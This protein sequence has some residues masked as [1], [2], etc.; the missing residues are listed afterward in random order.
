MLHHLSRRLVKA[1]GAVR[2]SGFPWATP[3]AADTPRAARL[4]RRHARARVLDR[5][6]ALLR[7]LAALLMTVAWP[8]QTLV[9]AVRMARNAD[10]PARDRG[11]LARA[12]WRV[13]LRHNVPP[14]EYLAYR[15]PERPEVPVDAWLIRSEVTRLND[16]LAGRDAALIAGDKHRFWLFCRQH[17]LPAVLTLALADGTAGVEPSDQPDLI[18]KPRRAANARGI[19]HWRKAPDGYHRLHPEPAPGPP[20][21]WPGLLHRAA[22]GHPGRGGML[23]QPML[24]LHP[25]LRAV[26]P[27]GSPAARIVTG[28]AADGPI[29][30]LHASFVRPYPGQMVSNGGA[31]R[32]VDLATG[33]LLPPEPGRHRPA[34]GAVDLAPDL[35]GVA[36]P[37]WPRAL[38][39]VLEAHAALP[40][41]AVLL[42]WDVAFTPDGPVLIE[43]NLG[44]SCY[45]QQTDTLEPAGPSRL[46]EILASWLG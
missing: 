22:A 26:I 42:G 32:Q 1:L 23:V 46:A 24:P 16:A 2:S 33:R 9:D 20:L 25:A 36:L 6:P 38:A 14:L 11:K 39:L 30:P 31:R 35:E 13:A 27:S 7:P 43:V 40:G 5:F 44:I 21:D 28:H 10:Y 15:M 34:F 3:V 4:I 18:L 29:E 17:G 37:D 8:V 45:L 19:E 41:R 12:A